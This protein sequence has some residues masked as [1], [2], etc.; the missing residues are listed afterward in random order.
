MKLVTV[1]VT[2]SERLGLNPTIVELTTTVRPV[3]G[4]DP[5]TPLCPISLRPI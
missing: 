5:E 2:S 1:A 3:K 4:D